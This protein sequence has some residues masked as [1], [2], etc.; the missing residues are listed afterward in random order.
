MK[1]YRVRYDRAQRDIVNE[2]VLAHDLDEAVRVALAQSG[3][4]DVAR[5]SRTITLPLGG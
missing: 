2:L 5:M 3:V 4:T 1:L